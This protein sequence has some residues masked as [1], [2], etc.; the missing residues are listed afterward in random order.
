MVQQHIHKSGKTIMFG[1]DVSKDI[2]LSE[3]QKTQLEALKEEAA[4]AAGGN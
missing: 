3:E 2:E 4:K 1:K